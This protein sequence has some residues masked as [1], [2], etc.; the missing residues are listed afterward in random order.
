MRRRPTAPARNTDWQDHIACRGSLV[1]FASDSPREIAAAKRICDGC[2]VTQEC[3]DHG[4][5]RRQT[6]V[7]GG[8]N[9]VV[10]QPVTL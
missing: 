8:V 1:D 5:Y 6:G 7:Y 10:G 2:P 3:F 9:L 4:Q